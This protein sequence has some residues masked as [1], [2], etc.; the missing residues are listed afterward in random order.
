MTLDSGGAVQLNIAISSFFVKVLKTVLL[1]ALDVFAANDD[2]IHVSLHPTHAVMRLGA[3][4][5]TV[6]TR[7]VTVHIDPTHPPG[8]A[9]I[10]VGDAWLSV[11]IDGNVLAYVQ[12]P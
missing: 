4:S 2:T 9:T 3:L 12:H 11:P 5:F 10:R 1:P 8:R 6:G 7:P